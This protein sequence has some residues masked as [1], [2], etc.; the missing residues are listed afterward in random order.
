MHLYM[1]NIKRMVSVFNWGEQERVMIAAYGKM[2]S[3]N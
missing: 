1:A 2:L 3:V